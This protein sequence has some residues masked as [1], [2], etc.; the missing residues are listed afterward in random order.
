MVQNMERIQPFLEPPWHM[1]AHDLEDQVQIFAPENS[2]GLSLKE[3]WMNDHL[4]FIT[5]NEHNPDYLFVYSDGSCSESKG[6]RKTGFGVV[7]YSEG[8]V[9]F[10]N[11][12]ALSEHMEAYDTE[13]AGLNAAAEQISATLGDESHLSKPNR[14]VIY[15]DNT[16]ALTRIIQAN[17]GKAQTHSSNFRKIISRLLTEH[18]NL[19]I[20]LS[21]CPGNTGGRWRGHG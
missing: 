16:A 13:M 11:K 15:A 17:P 3:S 1:S 9:V 19:Q 8:K 18:E 5:E 2:P 7:G 20:T 4:E 10:E 6:I 14:V 12:G 21:W